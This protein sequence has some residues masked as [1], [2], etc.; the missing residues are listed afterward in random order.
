MRVKE[1]DKVRI[2]SHPSPDLELISRYPY[3]DFPKI[4]E[5]Y[6]VSNTFGNI[7]ELKFKNPVR[8]N[9]YWTVLNSNIKKL[10]HNNSQPPTIPS[11]I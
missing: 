5:I 11:I 2:I 9:S 4:G 7:I 8:R 1:G 10:P 6:I 3:L